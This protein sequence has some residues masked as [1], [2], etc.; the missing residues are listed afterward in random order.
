M[1]YRRGDVC[2]A[3]YPNSDLRTAKRRPVV[4]IQR[5]ELETGLT[6]LIVAMITSNMLRADHPSRVTVTRNSAQGKR[7]GLLSDSVVM[8]DNLATVHERAL[9]RRIGSLQM[10]A[11]DSAMKHT[12][13]LN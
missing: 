5:D 13:G 4:I 9:A 2:L 1:K 12:L 11:I 10:D 8:T 7:S 3:L 6:Q